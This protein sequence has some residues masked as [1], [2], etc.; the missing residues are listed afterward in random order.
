V[1]V[2]LRSS[3]GSGRQTL[4][5]IGLLLSWTWNRVVS[6]C[7]GGPE[8]TSYY[9]YKATVRVMGPSTCPTGQGNQTQPCLIVVPGAPLPFGPNISDPGTGRTVLSWVD[10][11]ED[12]DLLP[13]PP[14]GGFAAWPWPT[15]DNP[16]PVVA[17]DYAGNH[18]DQLCK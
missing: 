6:D 17:V 3:S 14:L 11:V 1:A 5:I 13:I 15:A 10:P 4:L 12:P 7:H 2:T 18:C 16:N 9:Y 8:R